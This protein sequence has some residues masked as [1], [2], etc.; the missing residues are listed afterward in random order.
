MSKIHLDKSALAFGALLFAMLLLAGAWLLSN[1]GDSARS[2][3]IADRSNTVAEGD[4][5]DVRGVDGAYER[6]LVDSGSAGDPTRSPEVGARDRAEAAAR[7]AQ[8]AVLGRVVDDS[9]APV[10]G[11]QVRVAVEIPGTA[12]TTLDR[13]TETMADG[14][15]RVP[16]DREPRMLSARSWRA[17]VAVVALSD[18][19]AVTG[20]DIDLG[21]ITLEP[22]GILEGRVVR[23]DGRPAPG[24]LVVAAPVERDSTTGE[25]VQ[26]RNHG[27]FDEPVDLTGLPVGRCLAGEGG[28]F[29]MAGLAARS[30]AVYAVPRGGTGRIY[31]GRIV[32]EW[33]PAGSTGIEVIVGFQRLVVDVVDADGASLEGARV[34]CEEVAPG[35]S[36]EVLVSDLRFGRTD[37]EGAVDFE[38]RSGRSYR[39]RAEAEGVGEGTEHFEAPAAGTEFRQRLVLAPRHA[40][41]GRIRVRVDGD[42]SAWRG[43]V[44]L[45]NEE[46]S[47]EI[48]SFEWSGADADEGRLVPAGTYT[49]ALEVDVY[50]R[51]DVYDALI[52]PV[53]GVV[54]PA[55]GDRE[56]ALQPRAGGRFRLVWSAPPGAFPPGDAVVPPRGPDTTAFGLFQNEHGASVQVRRVLSDAA[57]QELE[58]WRAVSVAH[59]P[60]EGFHQRK[61]LPDEEYRSRLLLDPG[62]YTLRISCPGFRTK[63]AS[64]D[65]RAWEETAVEVQLE[66]L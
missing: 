32:E 1:S 65:V 60:D 27:R 48:V 43:W 12:E 42:V 13:T 2:G 11:A 6:D 9:G 36:G 58:F 22:L 16:L 44:T 61:L 26:A 62:P 52:E 49:V 8:R 33:Y 28:R 39:L 45:E 59:D 30:Y 23:R 37:A 35:A 18:R 17:G 3:L 34:R 46:S 10:V 25:M 53:H 5:E 57:L 54:V 29:Q 20:A 55:G 47:E 51:I 7:S 31:T 15:F 50:D 4:A 41:Q 24:A 14:R 64:F 66:P 40:E 19:A 38:V 56:V 63:E 21:D